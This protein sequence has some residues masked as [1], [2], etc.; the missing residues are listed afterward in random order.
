MLQM[1][2]WQWLSERGLRVAT[3][4]ATL[5]RYAALKALRLPELEDIIP[6]DG[7][8]LLVLRPGAAPSAGLR[9]ALAAPLAE[10]ADSAGTLHEIPVAYGGANGPDLDALAER[11]GMGAEDFVGR[12]AAVEYTVAF[13]GFQPGFPYLRGLPRALQA[14]R[15]SSPRARVA[16]G[17]VGIG[18]AYTGIY[19]AAGPGGWQIIGRTQAVLFDPRRETPALLCPGDRLR[20][21]PA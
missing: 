17:S 11:A 3:G 21:V 10:R 19:P 5:A 7:S 13:I 14:P 16:A 8:L 18:G 9:A 1:P 6:A 12:H 2:P 20:F 4:E 15:R